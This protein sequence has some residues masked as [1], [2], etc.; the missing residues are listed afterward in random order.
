[1]GAIQHFSFGEGDKDIGGQIKPFKAD[2]GRSYRVSFIWW[3]G[4][5]DGKPDLDSPAPQFAGANANFIPNVG[6][7]INKGP[8][9][10][11][12]AG[13]KAPRMRIASV[14]AVWPTDK[15]AQVDKSA[16]QRGEIDILPWV[17]SGDKFT[18]LKNINKEFP[19]GSHDFTLNC[20]DANFQ[21]MT[22]TPCRDSLLR[23]LLG[24]PKAE[25]MVADM[26]AKAQL[27][28]G[29]ISEHVGREM[30]VQQIREK[31]VGGP[32]G[33]HGGGGGSSSAVD[34][35]ATGDIDSMVDNMLDS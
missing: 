31:L 3:K 28:S 26:I 19:F 16:L 30:T 7:I 20:T 22:F 18:T 12:L 35:M 2:A 32:G 25:S 24:N 10:T 14:I 1:M 23:A 17:I 33:G 21:K 5:E 8:E 4:L 15:Q 6:F 13:D 27:I 9:Y 11:K 29:G 34:T